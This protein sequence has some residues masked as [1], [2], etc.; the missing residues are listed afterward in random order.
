V[1]KKQNI[2]VLFTVCILCALVE[3]LK[4][5]YNKIFMDEK[6]DLVE[7]LQI[8]SNTVTYKLYVCFFNIY[9][10]MHRNNI[11][12]YNSDTDLLQTLCTY[13]NPYIRRQ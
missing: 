6:Q 9:G 11:L 2:L 3:I 10:S 12:V 13:S 4:K 1:I 5:C 7:K 8:D